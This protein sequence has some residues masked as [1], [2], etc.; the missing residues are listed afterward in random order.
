[1]SD[2]PDRSL[3]ARSLPARATLEHLKSQAKQRLRTMRSHD[4]AARLSE[5]Q[6]LVA[7]DY[8][9]PSWRKMKSYVEALNDVGERLVKAVVDS[10]LKTIRE[11]L[12]RHPE[13]VKA[14]TEIDQRGLIPVNY[15]G[16]PAKPRKM[17]TLQLLHL[18]IVGGKIDV[19]R[20]LIERGADLN[21]R[22]ADGRLPLHDCFELNHD[23]FT[24]ILLEAGAVV[25]VCAAA[26]YG[27]NDRL[28]EILASHREDANDLR[29]GNSP[30]GWAAYGRQP[31]SAKILLQYGAVVD[32]APYDRKAWQ[33]AAMVA[34]KD[35]ARVLLEHG[36]DP[37]W[38]DEEGN[39]PIH[40]VIRSRIVRDPAEFVK[41]LVEFGADLRSENLLGR[42]ALD[43]A[44][45]QA[46]KNAETY[47]PIR[48]IAEKRLEGTI[49]IL[50]SRQIS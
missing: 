26:A 14:N 25:D 18:A 50:R 12:D 9:F 49:A 1:M 28:R 46:G 27:M 32:R 22:N 47:F 11:V 2:T 3:S 30:L 16:A 48:P 13:L 8:G 38:R 43:E 41:V 34:S 20:L 17:L 19:L 39:T 21:V 23:D 45:M 40:Y 44:L 24:T 31:Q 36:A 15:A 35:V 10:D 6:L 42:T 37:N 7:R 5:A 4:S 33:P 29:T